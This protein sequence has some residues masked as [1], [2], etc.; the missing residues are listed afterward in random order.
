MS[1]L[2]TVLTES[3]AGTY[4]VERELGRGGMAT[5]FLAQDVKHGRHVAIKVLHPELASSMGAER[6][7]R[8]IEIAAR[9]QHPNI[10]PLYDSGVAGEFLYYV[11]PFVE[12]ETLR[13]RMD[14]EK[15]LGLED[16]VKIAL[17]VAAAL[18]YAHSRGVVHRDIKP[19]NVMLS[20]GVAVVADFGIARALSVASDQTLTQTGTVVG[21]PAYMSPEQATGSDIDGRSDQYSLACMLYEMLVGA[22]PFTGPNPQAVMARHTMDNVSPPTIVRAT[23][24]DAVEDAILKAMNKVPADRFA[25]AQQFAEALQVLSPATGPTRR[26]TAARYTAA[27]Q[28]YTLGAGLPAARRFS[29]RTIGLAAGVI[30]VMGAVAAWLWLPRSGRAGGASG[31][32]DPR[33]VAVRY[34]EDLSPGKEL[35]YL[36][37]GL[38]EGLIDQLSPVPGLSV[39]SRNGVAPYRNTDVSRDSI[40]RALGVGSLIEGTVEPVA[41]RLRVTVRLVDGPSGADLDRKSYELAA[42]SAATVRDSITQE[43]SRML[44]A[45]LGEEIRMR[46]RRAGTANVDAWVFLQRGERLRKDAEASLAAADTA[47]AGR[48]LASADSLFASASSRDAAWVRPWVERGWTAHQQLDLASGFDPEYYR[49]WLTTGLG[50]AERALALAGSDADGLELRG[51]VRYYQWILNLA[52]NSAAADALLRGAQ[53]DLEGSVAANPQQAGAWALLSHLHMRL[54][55]TAEGKLAAL[56]AYEADPYLAQASSVLWRLYQ[57]SL[58][59]EDGVEAAKWCAEGGR[60]FPA[61][62]NFVECQITVN[63]LP[64]Q[65]PDVA[66]MWQLLDENVNLYPPNQREY[67]R[68]RGEM[69]VAMTLV[70][71]GLADSADHVALRA[72]GPTLDPTTDLVYIE[73]MLRNMMGDRDEALRLVGVHLAANPQDR[74]TMAKDYTWWWAGIRDDPRFKALVGA[75]R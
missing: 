61:E 34:F 62:R 67:R 4:A 5:V 64:G 71:A 58:D 50:Y 44:R 28:G 36:A 63:A 72:R 29:P 40:A 32:L 33:T 55:R 7:Q 17:E 15:Q 70:R 75:A 41:G 54:S 23:I 48:L 37:D 49:R 45:R 46:E 27:G 60:R 11:M 13:D 53:A 25:T 65:R 30:L 18:S 39:I 9:L 52:P 19:E 57:S 51:T 74:A 59:L 1:D 56:R 68:R 66:R 6:F 43:V 3:L 24:P 12:G 38:T 26:L 16:A 14:R 42:G 31:G 47:A 2:L 21:T 69:L 10:L 73:A 35:G 22:P 20:A 8:E